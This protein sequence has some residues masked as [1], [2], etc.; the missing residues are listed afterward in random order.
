MKLLMAGTQY[1]LQKQ[2]GVV[3]NASGGCQNPSEL[4]GAEALRS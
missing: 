2:A 1:L 4:S 3:L